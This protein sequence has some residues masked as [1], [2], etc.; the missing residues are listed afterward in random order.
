M[1][2]KVEE[3]K[4]RNRI[5]KQIQCNKGKIGMFKRSSSNMEEDGASSAILLLACI[6]L[7]TFQP[8]N[9]CPG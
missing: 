8:T 2:S 6:A 9:T 5:K 7:C 1:V 3:A 4:K